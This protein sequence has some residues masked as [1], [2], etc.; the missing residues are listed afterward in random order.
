MRESDGN[1]AHNKLLI[2][3]RKMAQLSLSGAGCRAPGKGGASV[4]AGRETGTLMQ[5]LATWIQL[6]ESRRSCEVL[7][8][9]KHLLTFLSLYVYKMSFTWSFYSRYSNWHRNNLVL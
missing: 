1:A 9:I 3:S 2:S 7:G 4:C 8:K 6:G 5:A